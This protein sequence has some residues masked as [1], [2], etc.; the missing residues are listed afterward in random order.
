MVHVTWPRPFQGWFVILGLALSTINLST[1]FE[2]C[3]STHYEDMKGDAK[4]Q[5]GV[6]WGSYGHSRSLE[7]APFDRVKYEFLL[8]FTRNYVPILHH[9][10]DIARYWSKIADH[11]LPCVYLA[12][13]LGVTRWKYT[14]SFGVRKLK[15]L[16][17]RRAL[18]SWSCLAILVQH[19][20]VMDGQTD[21]R[22]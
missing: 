4:C 22:C 2:I 15:S 9:F 6:V 20:R 14:E 13:L 11:N 17:Y 10:R 16:Y 8:A 12:P 3:I 1:R 19:R 21:T 18:F 7:I 5:N